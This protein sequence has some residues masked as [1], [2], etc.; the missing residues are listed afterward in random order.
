M[1]IE[2]IGEHLLVGQI[3]NLFLILSFSSVLFS[4]IAYIAARYDPDPHS[5]WIALGRWGY[6]LH[7]ILALSA[8]GMIFVMLANNYFE[9][10]YVWQHSNK[11][12]PMRYILSAF[13]EGQEGSFLLWIFWHVIIGNILIYTSKRWEGPVMAVLGMVQVLLTSMVLGV[14]LFEH[15]IGSN[16]FS[17]LLRE[18][19]DFAGL[20][21][22]T[23]ADYLSHLDGRG[24]NPLLQNYWM[25]IHPPTLFLGFAA[26][27]V[28]FCYA[29]AGLWTRQLTE[30]LRPAIPWTFFGVM[31]L[32]TGILMGGAW[33]YEALSFGGFWAWD[34]VENASLVPWITLVGAAHLMLIHRNKGTSL[35]MLFLL[36]QLSFL[37]VLYST[38]L[39]RSGIL[40]DASVHAFTDLG[41]QG[42]LVIYLLFF[43]WLGV[44]MLLQN[45]KLQEYY[46][47][48]TLGMVVLYGFTDSFSYPLALQSLFTVVFLSIAYKRH[49]PKP[50]KEEELWSREFWM[51]VGALVLLVSA[52]QI[53]GY[54]SIPVL[55]TLTPS[56]SWLWNAFDFAIPTTVL[57]KLVN[58]SFA[59]KTDGEVYNN[60]QVPFAILVT[61]FMAYGQ[62]L[63][64]KNTQFSKFIKRLIPSIGIALAL[65]LAIAF[66]FEMTDV[67]YL[68]LLF[69][70]L[71]AF[72]A[73]ADYVL[74][75]LKGKVRKA[76]ASV[77]HI[78]FALIM[79]G[80]LIS[81]SEQE[82]I[83]R[84]ATQ[85][86]VASLSEDFKNEENA[87]LFKN[88]TVPMGEYFVS[89]RGKEKRGINFYYLVDYY[90]ENEAKE[91]EKQFTLEP[92][93]QLNERMGNVPEPGTKHFFGRDVFTHI[94]FAEV[95]ETANTPYREPEQ[96]KMHLGDTVKG[97]S[98]I[99]ILDTIKRDL[100]LAELG[101]D[102]TD[103][104]VK[105]RLKVFT[106]DSEISFAEP[107]FVLRGN[108]IFSIPDTVEN[109][110]RF[111]FDLI[112][113]SRQEYAITVE[114]KRGREYIVMQAIIFP[115]I[116]VLWLGALLMAIGTVISIVNRIKLSRKS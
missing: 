82:F 32:G 55:N 42:Q 43:V 46:S 31:I 18:H 101:L 96:H 53:S 30:W 66:S 72:A 86:N 83:S 36:T 47:V 114:E 98:S 41:M 15:K 26:T 33:A 109:G 54:T 34:P 56:F 90:K 17:I 59:P 81:N 50:E 78:G 69:T 113:P 23:H 97:S 38:F 77:A 112:N 103:L 61:L 22:F 44:V 21:L 13:W 85:Y 19:P 49:F 40:G 45:R 88:D 68:L 4:C 14:Y 7:S 16:P 11:A 71:F 91:L 79:L 5:S 60:W 76:G 24:L 64:Y 102:S 9:Y 6:R 116:N 84:N 2:Y 67:F 74:M 28:P 70:S 105:A 62:F 107:V 92:F 93:V 10:H 25:T 73:N 57:D 80:A 12:M 111:T 87:I 108:H 106:L 48:A 104:A 89:Y 3:G 58:G 27:V 94:T 100:N 95:E 52:F 29:I 1:G 75:V 65:S 37:L 63:K 35:F 20:P 110:P 51:F 115:W 99:F 8:I 39:T